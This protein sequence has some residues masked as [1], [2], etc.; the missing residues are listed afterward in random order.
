MCNTCDDTG[1]YR[2]DVPVGD[3]HFGK[4]VRCHCKRLEDNQRLQRL[5]G[6]TATERAINL[7]HIQI[8]NLPG[9]SAMV[10]ACKMFMAHPFGI[11]TFW[12]GSGNGKTMVLQAVVNHYVDK[13]IEAIYI[14]AFDL[15][16][17]IRSAFSKGKGSDLEIK[18][19]NAY[20]RL[21]RFESVKVLAIDEF[22]KVRV[23]D[24][25][26]EQLTDLIDRRYRLAQD[27]Q[28]GTLLAMNDDPRDL[29]PWMYSRLAQNLIIHNPD[30][31]MRPLFGEMNAP[32]FVHPHTGEILR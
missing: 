27:E 1:Y 13:N 22:D 19:D 23:T 21:L 25:V 18:D 2:Y 12:G 29:P 10:Q 9:T 14:T 3:P 28:V 5:S 11:I 7:E 16:S 6:L 8:S 17:Y 15:I 4:M 30:N 24:W 32:S 26:Q 31:D 20:N